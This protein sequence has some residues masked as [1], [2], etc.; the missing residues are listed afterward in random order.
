MHT[1]RSQVSARR[2][3]EEARPRRERL[4]SGGWGGPRRDLRVQGSGKAST[5]PLDRKE[6]GPWVS[7][8]DRLQGTSSQE[9]ELPARTGRRP[10]AEGSAASAYKP[11]RR[12][13]PI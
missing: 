1:Q 4:E 5:A 2:P 11:S 3:P 13:G 7:R 12:V 6:E 8:P 10:R 9:P